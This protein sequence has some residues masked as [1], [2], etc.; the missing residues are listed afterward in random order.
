MVA[1]PCEVC[2]TRAICS[3]KTLR[4]AMSQCPLY[5]KYIEGMSKND[6]EF[7]YILQMYKE[8]VLTLKDGDNQ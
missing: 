2:I 5:F 8:Q 6:S 1:K 4:Q 3:N 7:S